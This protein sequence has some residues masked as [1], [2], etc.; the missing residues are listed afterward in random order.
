MQGIALNALHNCVS[1]VPVV[2]SPSPSH[3]GPGVTAMRDFELKQ[4]TTGLREGHEMTTSTTGLRSMELTDAD[5]DDVSG[6][7]PA[8]AVGMAGA[9]VFVAGG[10]TYELAD[11]IAQIINGAG[12][13]I[14][15]APMSGK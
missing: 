9:A 5:L 13:T 10:M 14:E 2:D 6:G 15:T 7:C 11:A 8:C 12:K 3:I 4:P 1:R